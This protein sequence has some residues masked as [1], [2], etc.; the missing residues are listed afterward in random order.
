M[1]ISINVEHKFSFLAVI[2]LDKESS[3]F[4]SIQ[5]SHWHTVISSKLYS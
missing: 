4:E 5:T 3:Q 1:S 2:L